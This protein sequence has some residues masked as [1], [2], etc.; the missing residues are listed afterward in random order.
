MEWSKIKNIIL[1]IL[2]LVNGFLL[3]LVGGQWLQERYTHHTALQN[4]ARILEQNGIAISEGAA[5]QL[6]SAALPPMT[7]GRD[8]TAEG[9]LAAALLGADVT[10]ADQSGGVYLY[11][12]PVGSAV[13][14]SGGECS[15]TFDTPLPA[16][17]DPAAHA[18]SCLEGLGLEGE[19]LSVEVLPS[20]KTVVTLRQRL[21]GVP[22]YS[23]R[24]EF[25]YGT[26][27]LLSIRGSL[28]LAPG[29]VTP[30]DDGVLDSATAL[31]RFLAAIL[32][33]G[34]L[35][36]AV[37]DLRPGY[38]AATSFGSAVTLR[39]VWLVTTDVSQYYLDC[40]TGALSRVS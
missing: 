34:D 9:A 6:S 18:L 35:C 27:G 37:T 31:I 17:D 5:Q 8:L 23:C 15:V 26:G 2:L 39:P 19:R 29:A 40:T 20:E 25:V 21:D 36:S 22:L 30:S 38:L 13:F 32:D 14:R 3:L 28:I 1:M 12:S 24:V 4:G 7:A 10:C 16:G 33:S 11:T